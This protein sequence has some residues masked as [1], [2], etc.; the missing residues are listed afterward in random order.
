[1]RVWTSILVI[2]SAEN[3]LVNLWTLSLKNLVKLVGVN[4]VF[5]FYIYIFQPRLKLFHSS[6]PKL[7]FGHLYIAGGDETFLTF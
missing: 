3:Y 6:Y 1:M 5:S 2:L 4:F 7:V